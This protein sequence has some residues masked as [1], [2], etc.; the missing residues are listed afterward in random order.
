[1]FVKKEWFKEWFDSPYYHVLYNNRDETEA[2][3]FINNL[4]RLMQLKADK[5]QLIDLACG[6]GRH[7]IF[8]NSLGF[9]VKGVDLSE[10]SI[11][12]AKQYENDTLSF[13]VQDLRTLASENKFEVAL[14]L[15]TSFGYFQSLEEDKEVLKRIGAVLKPGGRLVIDFMNSSKVLQN[16]VPYESKTK[17]GIRFVISKWT[18][19]NFICKKISVDDDDSS[20][21]FTEKVQALTPNDFKEILEATG[22][23][24]IHTFGNYMLEPFVNNTSERFILIAQKID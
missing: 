21:E 4:C 7:S 9:T 18:E 14:N 8:L 12:S 22:F 20:L 11:K 6:K 24:I 15:F 3:I 23:K 17:N 16:L 2:H 19:S 5:E 13:E 1:M 10:H